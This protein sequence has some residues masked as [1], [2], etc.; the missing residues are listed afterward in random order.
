MGCKEE[1]KCP[2][3]FLRLLSG[4]GRWRSCE[5]AGYELCIRCT[6]WQETQPISSLT[7]DEWWSG[8][9][10]THTLTHDYSHT[11]TSKGTHT[12]PHM[13]WL[14]MSVVRSIQSLCLNQSNTTYCKPWCTF[15]LLFYLLY[16]M[17]LFLGL[18]KISIWTET[19][20]AKECID[21]KVTFLLLG[22]IEVEKISKLTESCTF[23]I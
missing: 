11:H 2:V 21:S 12:H 23:V 8:V 7:T 6:I 9:I 19:R 16:F 22:F 1:S 13:L 4:T 3:F 18:C 5:T 20:A 15:I 14:Q 10:H 17:S